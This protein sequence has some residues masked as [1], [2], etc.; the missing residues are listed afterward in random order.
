MAK[1]VRIICMTNSADTEQLGQYLRN[2]TNM[3]CPLKMTSYPA[4]FP[5]HT[6]MADMFQKYSEFNLIKLSLIK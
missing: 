3:T 1:V 6:N 5:T 2:S 4:S